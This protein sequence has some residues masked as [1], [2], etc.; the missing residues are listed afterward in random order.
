MDTWCLGLCA[1]HLLTGDAPY[2]EV[3]ADVHCPTSLATDL[4]AAWSGSLAGAWECTYTSLCEVLQDEEDMALMADTA[5]RMVVLRGLPPAARGAATD[6]GWSLQGNPVLHVLHKHLGGG[7]S[8]GRR[9]RRRGRRT[10][11]Q[12]FL[13]HRAQFGLEAGT[14]APHPRMA[15]LRAHCAELPGMAELLV[16]LLQWRPEQRCAMATALQGPVFAPLQVP[17]VPSVEEEE[18]ADGVVVLPFQCYATTGVE[19]EA[20]A[21][22]AD[23]RVVVTS[24][25]FVVNSA[26]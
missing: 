8:G 11:H 5:Y 20:A 21:D 22:A 16:E 14:G 26:L 18:A 23:G 19:E 9:R 13:L 3:M 4:A 1:V 7:G 6:E 10:A 2:E 12:E 15:A 17:S 25:G 24:A